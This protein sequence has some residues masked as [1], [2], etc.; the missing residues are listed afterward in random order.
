MRRPIQ[1]AALMAAACLIAWSVHAVPLVTEQGATM[2]GWDA[3][4]FGGGAPYLTPDPPTAVGDI[5]GT[6]TAGLQMTGPNS[7]QGTYEDRVFNTTTL[8]GDWSNIG[9][10]QVRSIR[11]DFF[12]DTHNF[13]VYDGTTD[14]PQ[15]L[16]IYWL[17]ASGAMWAL[18]VVPYQ[19]WSS[20]YANLDSDEAWIDLNGLFSDTDPEFGQDMSN[21]VAEVGIRLAYR[22]GYDGARFGI[23]SF[24]LEDTY[25]VIP[26]P[27]TYAMLG[28]AVLSLGITF[29]RRIG[30]KMGAFVSSLKS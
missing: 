28:M 10:G 26:E 15:Q 1:I 8:A 6:G 24:T 16:S 30:E 4:E 7:P 13:G 19:N 18:T 17:G 22:P 11:M 14:A 21:T 2:S 20:L 5:H 23:S 29:R 12:S 9:G 25:F 3:E 27:R